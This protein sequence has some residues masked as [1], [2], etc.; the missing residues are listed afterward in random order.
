MEAQWD[1]ICA[2]L[3]DF[4]WADFVSPSDG[5]YGRL[6]LTTATL[7][8]WA[9]AWTQLS[10]PAPAGIVWVQVSRRAPFR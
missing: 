3:N 6:L 10:F 4:T 8:T 7:W 2:R 9:G 5:R 1:A